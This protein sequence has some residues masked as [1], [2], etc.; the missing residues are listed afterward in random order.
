MTQPHAPPIAAPP[1]PTVSYHPR[2]DRGAEPTQET[3]RDW[4]LAERFGF[5]VLVVY[6]ALYT[7]PGPLSELYG[8][9]FI[10]NPY[11]AVWRA[12][13]PWFGAHILRLGHPISIQPSGSGDKLFDWVEIPLQLAIALIVAVVWSLI[14]RR[15]RSHPKLLAAFTIYLS[16][17]MARTMFSYGFDKVIPNQFSPMDPARL[18]QYIGET[19]P[20][21]FAWTFLGFS[22]P[23]EIFA[24]SA[25]T[26][27]ATLLLLRRTP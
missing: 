18:T 24:G 19:S 26:L 17:T 20:G 4:T 25:D 12:V 15:R 10:S 22:I 7:F 27:A 16:L 14:D 3:T 21:G 13:V 5:R 6:V 1:V 8:T 23:Y 9:D 11:S 2:S